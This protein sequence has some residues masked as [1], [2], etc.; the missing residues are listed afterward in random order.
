MQAAVEA[1]IKQEFAKIMA[2]GGALTPNEA[3]AL[4]YKRVVASVRTRA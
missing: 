2:A 4:A 1:A 3:A